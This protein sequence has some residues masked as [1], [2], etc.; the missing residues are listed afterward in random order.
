[1]S[2]V[3]W[4]CGCGTK[5]TAILRM[6]DTSMTVR[7]PTKSCT[8]TRTLPGEI[9]KLW[10]ETSSGVWRGVNVSSGMF[11][12]EREALL[13]AFQRAVKEC[14]RAAAELSDAVGAALSADADLVLRKAAQVRELSR[15]AHRLLQEHRQQHGC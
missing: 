4:V 13:A 11:C 12:E 14:G 9:T 1:M 5:V 6:T 7:C 8:V 2:E 15:H 10:V 3:F